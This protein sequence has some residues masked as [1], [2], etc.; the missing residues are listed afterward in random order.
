MNTKNIPVIVMLTAGLVSSIVMYRMHYE[1]YDMLWILLL[2]FFVFYILGHLVKKV[3]DKFCAPK[4][5]KGQQEEEKTQEPEEEGEK[6]K[7]SKADD[8]THRDGSVIEKA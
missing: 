5:E 3:L 2:V 4:E 1:L 7:E 8:D 6:G